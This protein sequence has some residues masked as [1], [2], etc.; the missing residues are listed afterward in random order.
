MKNKIKDVKFVLMLYFII[1]I[2]VIGLFC[3][4]L[5]SIL[6]NKINFFFEM[7]EGNGFNYL[8]TLSIQV[9]VS[10]IV[11]SVVTVLSQKNCIIYWQDIMSYKLIDP[12]LTNFNALASYVFADLLLSIFFVVIDSKMVYI[13]FFVTVLLIMLL[14][15][16]MMEVYFSREKIKN[17]MANQYAKERAHRKTSQKSLD[18]YREH[19]RKIIQYTIQ[20]IDE[21]NID[22]VCENLEL[23]FRNEENDDSIYIIKKMLNEKKIYTLS[24]VAKTNFFIFIQNRYINLFCDICE[25]ILN[26]SGS[27]YDENIRYVISI[28]KS[29]CEC[30]LGEDDEQKKPLRDSINSFCL[31]ISETG[32]TETAEKIQTICTEHLNYQVL[33]K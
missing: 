28:F 22:V 31:K 19:K 33:G 26:Q 10:F 2:S 20:A 29:M 30:Y 5:N 24:R 1:G 32:K 12:L 21:N 11:V 23:L 15:L 18:L 17:Q 13:C 3:F 16:K 9:S 25:K 7:L 14:S 4:L 27:E 6:G 8:A